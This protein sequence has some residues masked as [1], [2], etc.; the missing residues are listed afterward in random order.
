MF[1][2]F[3]IKKIAQV[4]VVFLIQ[5]TP[6]SVVYLWPLFDDPAN[7]PIRLSAVAPVFAKLA[8]LTT[9]LLFKDEYKLD[10]LKYKD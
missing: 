2:F 9:P 6:Y 3:L 8:V 5:W 7:I 10:K 4:A 1:I